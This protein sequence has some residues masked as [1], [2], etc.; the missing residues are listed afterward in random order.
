MSLQRKIQQGKRRRALRVRAKFSSGMLRVSVFRSLQHVY[1]QIVDD[2]KR[3]T[4]VSCS[5]HDISAAKQAKKEQAFAVGKELARR[6]QA[7]GITAAVFDRGSFLYHGRIKAVA[8][9]LRDGG[10]HV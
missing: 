3:V 4:V 9:G 8:E 7:Q 6:A 1:A 10:L 2:A 5:T